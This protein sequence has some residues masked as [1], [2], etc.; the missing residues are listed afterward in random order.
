MLEALWLV[1]LRELEALRHEPSD[2]I[3]SFRLHHHS[4]AECTLGVA[5]MR[6][7][8]PRHWP[9]GRSK[10]QSSVCQLGGIAAS[11]ASTHR[12]VVPVMSKRPGWAKAAPELVQ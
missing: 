4:V 2:L 11:S 9:T 7:L 5:V 6:S 1:T 10:L 8:S 3:G 12:S